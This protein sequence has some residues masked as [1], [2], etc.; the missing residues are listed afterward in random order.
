MFLNFVVVL[1]LE[2]VLAMLLLFR[3]RQWP[4][5]AVC[6][7][8]MVAVLVIG[9]FVKGRFV[10]TKHFAINLNAS[11]SHF[12]N[13]G[14]MPRHGP[15]YWPWWRLCAFKVAKL[16]VEPPTQARR[17]WIYTRWGAPFF[18]VVFDRRNRSSWS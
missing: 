6:A 16:G 8:S 12:M 18:D 11:F 17:L 7:V 5:I 10:F 9:A 3:L 13:A 15:S 2:Y 14:L 1:A 4:S